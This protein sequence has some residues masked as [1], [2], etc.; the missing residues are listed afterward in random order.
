MRSLDDQLWWPPVFSQE[1]YAVRSHDG[2]A[3]TSYRFARG[4][5]GPDPADHRA[6]SAQSKEVTLPRILGH[7]GARLLAPENTLPGFRAAIADGADGVELDVRRTAD[8][9]LVCLHDAGLGR[10]TNGRGPVREHTLAEIRRL[11]AGARYG[12]NGHRRAVQPGG[13]RVGVPTLAEALDGLPAGALVDV[14]VKCRGEGPGGPA[15]VAQ[16]LAETLAGRPDRDRLLVSSFSRKLVAAAVPALGGI[17][18]GLV[19]SALVPLGRALRGAELCGCSL[20][21]AQASAYFGPKAKLVASRA[22]DAGFQLLAWTV[23]DP[24]TARRL[25]DLGVGLIVS[26]RPGE[27]RRALDA[28]PSPGPAHPGGE[29]E[30]PR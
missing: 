18:V 29:P 4:F 12:R 9:E 6:R 26:D 10:T 24:E 14:E 25:A 22:M 5:P 28:P 11:D 2:G 8:Q 16:L 3:G 17:R 30:R 20:L 15:R 21:A 23:D 27:L 1:N 19:S 13:A 7:R